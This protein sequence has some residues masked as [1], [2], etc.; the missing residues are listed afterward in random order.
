MRLKDKVAL[1]A[2]AGPGMGRATGRPVS[3]LAFAK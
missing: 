3:C 1:I 2:G